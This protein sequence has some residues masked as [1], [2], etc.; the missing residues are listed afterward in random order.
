MQKRKYLF[1]TRSLSGGGAEPIW[2]LLASLFAERGD[3]VVLAIDE[4]GDGSALLSP[5]VRLEILGTGNARSTL[6]AARLLR[7]FKPDATLTA[8]TGNAVKLAAAK[9]LVG[10]R[11]SLII[12]FHGFLEYKTGMLSAAGHY[13]LPLLSRLASR[14]V[15]VSDGLTR[16]MIERWGADPARTVRIYN[17]V[18][19]QQPVADAQALLARRPIVVALGRLSGDKGFDLLITAFGAVST[20]GARLIIAGK[21][22]EHDRLQAQID[23][24][25][26]ADR[27]ELA[28]FVDPATLYG[29]A[30]LCV[31]ASRSEAFG[32]V[33]VEALSAGLP[34]VVTDCDGPREIVDGGHFGTIVP[35]G[36]TAAMTR[37]IDAALAMP[38]DPAPRIERAR[39]FSVEAGFNAWADLLDEVLAQR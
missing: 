5:L 1:Y 22:A 17:P 13:G 29:M 26:L 32:L 20:P 23:R 4:E 28:G 3:E 21:G 27:I 10:S 7:S 36:D 11:T 8:I 16:T 30:R 2:A 38:G 25:G 39:I 9:L 35:I 15:C 34:L 24:L 6:A 19:A 14:I 18:P 31:I 12:S 33:A 37:A